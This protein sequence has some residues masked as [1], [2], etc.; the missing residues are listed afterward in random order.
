MCRSSQNGAWGTQGGGS[1]IHETLGACVLATAILFTFGNSAAR[2]AAA[3][4]QSASRCGLADLRGTYGFDGSGVNPQGP[5]AAVGISLFDGNGSFTV[6]QTTN[7]NGTI[8]QGGFTGRYEVFADC[9]GVWHDDSGAVIAYFVL[10][11]GGN[12]LLFL[13]I[14]PGNIITGHSKRVAPWSR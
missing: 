14:A 7:R 3:A 9:R 10:I 12:E 2:S 5:I 4:A 8:T 6:A 13:S 11:D 1:C